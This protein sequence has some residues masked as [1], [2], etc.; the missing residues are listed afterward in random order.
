[1]SD[2]SKQRKKCT[3]ALAK[4]AF[5]ELAGE[6]RRFE[7]RLPHSPEKV[8]RAL[9]EANEIE[10]W[11]PASIEGEVEEG[12]SLRFVFRD[13]AETDAKGEITRCDPPRE[14]AYTMGRETL[15]WELFPITEGTL[16]VLT[17]QVSLPRLP[18]NDNAI[19]ACRMAA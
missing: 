14:L 7:R 9:T 19:T 8:W 17:T 2:I 16:L 1:M 13:P 15:R 3:Q 6:V 5:L 18:A 11:F 4:G 12:A 10:R